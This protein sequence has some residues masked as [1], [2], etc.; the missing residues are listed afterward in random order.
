[1]DILQFWGIVYPM[2]MQHKIYACCSVFCLTQTLHDP[3]VA[4]CLSQI[5]HTVYCTLYK[6]HTLYVLHT[7]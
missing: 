7:N 1:M 3:D 5:I 4:S 2:T 6:M